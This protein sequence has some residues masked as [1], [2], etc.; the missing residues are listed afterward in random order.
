MKIKYSHLC[1]CS[2]KDE[3][4]ISVSEVHDATHYTG[5]I[6]EHKDQEDSVKGHSAKEGVD[7]AFDIAEHFSEEDNRFVI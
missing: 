6:L 7:L 4:K 3:V 1:Q 5:K 2:N